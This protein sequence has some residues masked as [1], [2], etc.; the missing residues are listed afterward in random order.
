MALRKKKAHSSVHVNDCKA[1][2][3][4]NLNGV[5]LHY[6]AAGKGNPVILLHGYAETSHMWR[7]ADGGPRGE[8]GRT[9]IAPD[10]RGAGQ[11]STPEA[12]YTKAEMAQ[13]TIHALVRETGLRAHPACRGMIWG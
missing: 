12:G 11:S 3:C 10:L 7:P 8:R 5:R 2:L 9:V 6:L 13:G 1:A 4:Q